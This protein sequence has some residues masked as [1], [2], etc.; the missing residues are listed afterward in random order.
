MA[1]LFCLPGILGQPVWVNAAL[2]ELTDC[3][4]PV[5]G[6]QM[7][8]APLP[9]TMQ[10]IARF[11]ATEIAGWHKSR[12][13]AAAPILAG[14]SLGGLL[15]VSVTTELEAM[16]LP[17]ARV[18]VVD[19]GTNFFPNP[20]SSAD[21]NG[22]HL[23]LRLTELRKD[24]VLQPVRTH[25]DFILATRGFPWERLPPSDDWACL[26]HGGMS[27]YP[28][29][30]HHLSI[31]QKTNAPLLAGL[32]KRLIEGGVEPARAI[33]DPW[34]ADDVGHLRTSA[35]LVHTGRYAQALEAL[36]LLS[37][38]RQ[39]FPAVVLQRLRLWEQ[40]GDL[41]A[42]K[43]TAHALLAGT[44]TLLPALVLS[45]VEALDRLKCGPLADRLD[46]TCLARLPQ[47][48]AGLLFQRAQRALNRQQHA[49]AADILAHPALAS[50]DPVETALI[51][52]MAARRASER[53]PDGW[54]D[55]L[56][57]TLASDGSVPSY[58]SAALRS[59]LV[60]GDDATAGAL[61]A[62]ARTMFPGDPASTDLVNLW[63]GRAAQWS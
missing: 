10:D 40:L 34:S 35:R 30:A 13:I 32:L 62:L 21:P 9:E 3:G 60:K 18:I 50:F 52:L 36:A 12:N 38:D 44:T 27:I 14:F 41:A 46:A 37:P 23:S 63:K 20:Q 22:E 47:P 48:S 1:P 19:P 43:A 57:S 39:A 24:H 6:L 5:L 49:V 11:H 54:H 56:L 15:T 42:L 29:D 53:Q 25:L 16:G 61:I 45:L 2:P 51:R 58:F 4:R 17:P 33:L 8:E 7:P 55:A 31:T 28:A 59:L 26:A